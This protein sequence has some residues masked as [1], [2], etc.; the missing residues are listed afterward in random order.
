MSA[1]GG[2][3]D[4]MVCR[5]PLLRSLYG[6]KADMGWCI[7]NVCL[8]PKADCSGLFWCRLGPLR[9]RLEPR[10]STMRRREFIRIVCGAL[11]APSIACA[12]TA[13]KIPTVAYLWH[14]ANQ[15]EESPY[16]EALLEGFSTLGYVDGGNFRLLHR[17]PNENPE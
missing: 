2:K 6:S 16:Y 5:S 3:A 4:M 9:W 8:C 15:K 13:K 10:R 1:F 12:Q 14:A 7:A 17:F 11:A